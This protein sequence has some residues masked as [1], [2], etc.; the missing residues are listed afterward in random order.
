MTDLYSFEA[1]TL[2]GELQS[3]SELKGKVVLVVNTASK[4]GFTPQYKGLESIY[5]EYKDKGFEMLGFPCNQFGKQEPG[6]SE[7]ISEFC[8][9]NFGVTFPLYEKVDV[10]GD[11]AHPLFTWLKSEAPG[12]LGTQAVKWNFTKF[13]VGRD[14][15]VIKRYAPKDKPESIV[16]DLEAAL[17]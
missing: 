8:E 16:A 6:G 2:T 17:K 12:L 9:L 5:Q 13:L 11:N 10:N 1:K 7:E 4:C 15:R 14:G 3:L